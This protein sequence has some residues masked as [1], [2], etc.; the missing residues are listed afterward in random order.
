MK[1]TGSDES[2]EKEG[3]NGMSN[4]MLEN[5]WREEDSKK[6]EK[7][8]VRKDREKQ[9]PFGFLSMF[10][11]QFCKKKNITNI[12]KTKK[13]QGREKK[14]KKGKAGRRNDYSPLLHQFLRQHQER[15]FHVRC[16]LRRCLQERKFQFL[17]Q[18]FC[19]FPCHLWIREI[20]FVSEEHPTGTAVCEAFH[21]CQPILDM[22][23]GFLFRI[24]GTKEWKRN[25]TQIKKEKK[26]NERRN[27]WMRE[28]NTSPEH[29]ENERREQRISSV[30]F[31]VS[32]SFV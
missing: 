19:F 6:D 13:R 16:R 28:G 29:G 1:K 30:V 3:D 20:G 17:C 25:E 31:V 32:F 8:K 21:L 4:R 15:S 10:C 11:G 22:I 24:N 26:R 12:E 7:K 18:G 9:D 27:E 14:R 2:T 23:E 5:Q